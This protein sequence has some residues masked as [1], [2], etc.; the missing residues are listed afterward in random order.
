MLKVLGSVPMC[1]LG[2]FLRGV[3]K[4]AA[5][6]LGAP[7]SPTIKNMYHRLIIQ[8]ASL[9]KSSDEDPDLVSGCCTAAPQKR[10]SLYIM[11]MC[12]IKYLLHLLTMLQFVTLKTIFRFAFY[13]DC[14]NNML[15][16][17][18]FRLVLYIK[19]KFKQ[20]SAAV[21]INGHVQRSRRHGFEPAVPSA[22]TD[23]ANGQLKHLFRFWA[24]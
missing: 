4:F 8:S 19:V 18:D 5:F 15:L 23:R 11:F 2:A 16:F 21:Q 1:G 7:V 13:H 20:N 24:N 14:T 3:C 9:I 22:S 12:P 6:P 10:I 17:F